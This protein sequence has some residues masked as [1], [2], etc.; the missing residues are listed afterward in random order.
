[1]LGDMCVD[2]ARHLRRNMPIPE[3]KLWNALRLLRAQGYHFRRQV[4]IGRRYYVDFCCHASGLVIEVDGDTH[5]AGNAPARDRVRDAFLNGEGYRVLRVPN[6]EVMHN[7]EGV[8]TLVL[9]TLASPAH[10]SP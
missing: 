2:R 7:L 6:G 1:M 5:F 3:A 8:M 10:P 9:H 4:E